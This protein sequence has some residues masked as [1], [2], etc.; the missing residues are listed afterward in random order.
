MWELLVIEH[1]HWSVVN[2]C[3]SVDFQKVLDDKFVF[4][5]ST[6]Q[7]TI[8]PAIPII[9]MINIVFENN[10]FMRVASFFFVYLIISCEKKS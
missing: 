1:C 2:N 6:G 7:A 9:Y 10:A 5:K 8:I 4:T 3:Y